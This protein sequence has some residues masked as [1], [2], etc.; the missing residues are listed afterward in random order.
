MVESA[1]FF[2]PFWLITTSARADDPTPR[3]RPIADAERHSWLW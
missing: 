2:F 3:P 1:A